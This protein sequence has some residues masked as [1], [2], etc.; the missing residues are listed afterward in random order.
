MSQHDHKGNVVE[1]YGPE[2]NTVKATHAA[3]NIAHGHV[4]EALMAFGPLPNTHTALTAE[5][6]D[7]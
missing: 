6:S 2:S 5:H 4:A 3:F 1:V 7:A